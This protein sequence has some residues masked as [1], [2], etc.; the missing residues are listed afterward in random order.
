M[1]KFVT[2]ASGAIWWPNLQLMQVAPSGGHICDS[3]KWCHLVAELN[4][5]YGVNF[6]VRCASGNVL[7]YYLVN[8]LNMLNFVF[9]I[10]WSMIFVWFCGFLCEFWG[11]LCEFCVILWMGCDEWG[12]FVVTTNW[13]RGKLSY[14]PPHCEMRKFQTNNNN[15]NIN[16]N[17]NNNNNVATSN[18]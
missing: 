18:W 3:C 15:S 5:S 9:P 8:C 6:W 12:W 16:N 7:G 1:A 13:Y 14:Q 2:H 11:F 4:P 17:N 10:I